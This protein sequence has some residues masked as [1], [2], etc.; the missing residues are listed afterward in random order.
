MWNVSQQAVKIAVRHMH[1]CAMVS[2]F[3]IHVVEPFEPV[4]DNGHQFIWT[5]DRRNAAQLAIAKDQERFR[6]TC[7]SN[8][9]FQSL[10]KCLQTDGARRWQN[11]Q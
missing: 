3:E 11:G 10:A 6:F 2:T 8:G 5:S 9:L 1:E 4:V 7:K